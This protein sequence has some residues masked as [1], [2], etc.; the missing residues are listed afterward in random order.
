MTSIL[1]IEKSGSI[2]ALKAKDVTL[3]TL[4]K[5]AGF[6]STEGFALATSWAIDTY[7]IHVYG[8]TKGKAGQENKYD[9]PP[10]IDS[11]LFFGACVLIRVDANNQI[12]DL[13]G[14]E[15]TKIYEKLFGGFEDLDGDDSSEL[16]TDEELEAL[17]QSGAV[18][19]QTKQGYVKDG[20]IVDS[21]DTE[22]ELEDDEE[23]SVEEVTKPVRKTVIK[24]QTI[25]VEIKKVAP[26]GK[27]G[28][29][30][31]VEAESQPEVVVD[32]YLDCTSELKEE[33]YV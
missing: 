26:K 10:P 12:I 28:K 14:D 4:Y 23:S 3:D 9:F 31:L 13:T 20:F 25:K 29:K 24:K 27:S 2:K 16:D 1:I 30:P 33:S 18:I 19:Q 6:K 22:E 7:T 32:N 21:D 8:K 17:Q 11:T 15:W 5:K